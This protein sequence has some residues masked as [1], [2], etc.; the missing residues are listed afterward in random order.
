H[1]GSQS[2]PGA[3]RKCNQCGAF[4]RP[5]HSRKLAWAYVLLG[6][7]SLS[8]FV[9]I[10]AAGMYGELKVGMF[11]YFPMESTCV[12]AIIQ[13]VLVLTGV[14]GKKELVQVKTTLPPDK[15]MPVMPVQQTEKA[16]ESKPQ[17]KQCPYCGKRYPIATDL[18]SVDKT[19]LVPVK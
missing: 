18:C 13:G 12:I 17:E 16:Q 3:V 1:R 8:I 11:K 6:A 15:G 10:R 4:W 5:A 2:Q 9:A 7:F 14:T 19:I